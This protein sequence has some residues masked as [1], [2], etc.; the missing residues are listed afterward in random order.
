MVAGG[1]LIALGASLGGGFATTLL[2]CLGLIAMLEAMFDL[3]LAARLLG[4]PVDGSSIR[5]IARG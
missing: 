4:C 5:G 1:L 2:A 3:C